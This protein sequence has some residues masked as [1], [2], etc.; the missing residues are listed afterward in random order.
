VRVFYTDSIDT[1]SSYA[2]CGVW[3]KKGDAK[4]ETRRVIQRSG[5]ELQARETDKIGSRLPASGFVVVGLYLPIV[6]LSNI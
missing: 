5:K 2:F 1:R 4:R 6:A 3:S